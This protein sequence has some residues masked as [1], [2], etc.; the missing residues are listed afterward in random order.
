MKK[1][2]NKADSEMQSHYDF[3]GGVRGKYTRQYAQG[4]NVV[5][6]EDDVARAFPTAKSVNRTLRAI[7]QIIRQEKSA[8][9]R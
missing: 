1:P 8:A 4:T 2:S 6:L 5:R 7:A 3:G 9:T